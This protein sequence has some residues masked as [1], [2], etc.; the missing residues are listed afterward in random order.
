[1][2]GDL[3]DNVGIE[4]PVATVLALLARGR[5]N[6]TTEAH[7][8]AGIQALLRAELPADISVIREHRLGPADR[9]DFWIGGRIAL[10][11]KGPRHQARPTLRQLARYA[12]HPE[13]EAVILATARAMSVPLALAGSA[14]GETVPIYGVNLGRA[15]L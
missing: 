11:V 14:P 9:V 10:E 2:R 12:A 8:Q 1:M 4:L 6:L 3:G 13:V 5:F 7:T 15:W